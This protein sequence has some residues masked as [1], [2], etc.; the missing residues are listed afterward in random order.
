MDQQE[1]QALLEGYFAGVD[2]GRGLERAEVVATVS[3]DEALRNVL[4]QYLP[5]GVY[6]NLGEVMNLIPAQAWQD[7]QGDRWRGGEPADAPDVPS[8][9]A[10]GPVGQDT[11][12]VYHQGG[13]QPPTPGFGHTSEAPGR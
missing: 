9:F 8:H 5:E 13:P 4:G 7:A 2:W 6:H 10:E 11:T 1:M 3:D 12:E